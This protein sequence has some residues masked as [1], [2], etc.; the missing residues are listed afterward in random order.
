MDSKLQFTAAVMP[1]IQSVSTE[2]QELNRKIPC[3]LSGT[4]A[5]STG[6]KYFSS[7]NRFKEFCSRNN[8]PFLPS[9]PNI[10]M[11][12]LV[13]VSDEAGFSQSGFSS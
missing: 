4:V 5:S 10:I 3:L 9:D 8:V 2:I 1:T 13:K 12:Y 7:F 6:D 11:A